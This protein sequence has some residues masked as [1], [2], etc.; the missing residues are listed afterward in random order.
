ME[1]N[2]KSLLKI[3]PAELGYEVVETCVGKAVKMPAMD[4][5]LFANVT[6]ASYLDNPVY[7]FT[8][9]GTTKILREAFR[10]NFVTGI[11]DNG[12][13]LYAPS[14]IREKRP[15]FFEGDKYVLLQELQDENSFRE[16]V[17]ALCN[18]ISANGSDP[19]NFLVYRIEV[20][21]KGNGMEPFLEYLACEYFKKKGYI[22]E[23]QIPLTHT[24][25]SPDF[26]GV[27]L[28]GSQR[29][30]HIIELAMMRLTRNYSLVDD[31]TIDHLIVG[32][33]K[34]ATTIMA[35]QLA[36]Y[37]NTSIFSKG[38][39]MHPDKSDPSFPCY[40]L[41]NIGGDYTVRCREP[42]EPYSNVGETVFN[43]D[44]YL[45]W[46]YNY[47]KLYIAAN[48]SNEELRDMVVQRYGRYSVENLVKRIDTIPIDEIMKW[49]KES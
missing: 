13:L 9:K 24:V 47:L 11:F 18:Q 12:Q 20:S 10:Y 44:E 16:T 30:F 41:F 5:Y 32:E 7:P 40:G 35:G 14:V 19:R 3:F 33:A 31:L 43:L 42:V 27:K 25:G 26:G 1:L 6:G 45:H 49:V 34:T 39:E 37:L 22:V 38:Y 46:Y 23:N 17:A 28:K 15:C 21:K 48:L 2:G 4:A 36:K 29:G 8:P